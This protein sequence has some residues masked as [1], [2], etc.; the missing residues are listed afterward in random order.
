MRA[1]RRRHR[2]IVN[3]D[4]KNEADDQ[5]A[6]VHALLSPS[7]DVRGLIAAHF[8]RRPGRSDRSMQDSREEIDL[9]LS[10]MDMTGAVP[11]A[12]GAPYAMPTVQTPVPSAGA[13][14]I[15][16]EAM[17]EDAEGTLFVA[18]LGP[19]TDMASALLLEPRIAERDI[20]V[21]WIGGPDYGDRDPMPHK[22][23]F[24]VSNDI[25][26][27]NIVFR[28][29]LPVWQ[30]PRSTYMQTAVSYAEL[31][32]K[33]APC[34][35]L[36]K[37]LVDQLVDFNERVSQSQVPMEYRCLGD[38]PAIGI[39]LNHT[40]GLYSHRPAHGFTYDG[41]YD[42]TREYRPIRVYHTIDSRFLFED[43]FAKLRQFTR[44]GQHQP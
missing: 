15:I 42:R 40:A 32:E 35:P 14:M 7:L 31:D 18:F 19:L 44:A 2:V 26:A 30:V 13:D 9:L 23:E 3:T 33:V 5:Y 6:I 34:G 12:N 16:E 36:G 37:Y 1:T 27:A 41:D 22:V 11:V 17:R 10:L 24:N 21:V 20:T 39:I 8:G 38:S 4:A 25:I 43:F 29:S 28:S